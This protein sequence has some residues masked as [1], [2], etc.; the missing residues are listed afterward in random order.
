MRILFFSQFY[1]PES[2][3]PSFRAAENS[4][5]WVDMGHDVTVFTGYPNYP[6]GKIF[7]GYVPKL[8]SEEKINGVRVIR[9]KLVAK[10][11]TNMIRR[12]ENALSF[13]FFGLVNIV[14]NSKKIG[15]KY[16]VVLGTSG[17]VF[18]AFLAQIYACMHKLTFIFE[19]RDITYIQMQA[20]GKSEKSFTVKGMK[21]LELYLCKKAEKIVVVTNGFKK[22]LIK[23]GIPE[24]KIMIVTNGVDV[25]PATGVY[26]SGKTFV[27]SYFG[28]LG[29]SQNIIDTFEYAEAI[30]GIISDFEYL[31]IGEGAQKQDIVKN[32]EE[33]GY[34]NIRMLPGMSADDLEPFYSRTQMSVITLRKTDNFRYTLPSKIFQIMGRGVAVLFI[35]PDGEAADIIR[36]YKAG[37]ALTGTK[38]KDI[39][40]LQEFFSKSSWKSEVE[41]MGE[42]GRKAVVNYYSR[43]DLAKKYADILSDAGKHK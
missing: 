29:L 27:L 38:D 31:I 9:N 30:S 3:A 28:T 16:D 1:T 22:I 14:F 10:P 12:L 34:K 37:I 17:V 40:Q 7:G 5:L 15:I 8:L 23:E 36:K 6:K 20:T 25:V 13:F 11:N 21:K 42:N 18:N 39:K 26:D 24:N 41:R 33:H 35:G 19:I 43:S 32:I 2:I 4:K